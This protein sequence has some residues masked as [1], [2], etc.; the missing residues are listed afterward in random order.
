MLAIKTGLSMHLAIV[1]AQSALAV[2]GIL[3]CSYI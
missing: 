2:S 1:A 3:F